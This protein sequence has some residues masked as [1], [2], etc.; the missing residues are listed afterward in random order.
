MITRKYL[1]LV[2]SVLFL[3]GCSQ[4]FWNEVAKNMQQQNQNYVD[5]HYE[6]DMRFRQQ[7]SD[8]QNNPQNVNYNMTCGVKPLPNIGCTIGRCVNGQWEEICN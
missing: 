4:S 2:L 7:W 5:P 1:I 8:N 6:M 3:T